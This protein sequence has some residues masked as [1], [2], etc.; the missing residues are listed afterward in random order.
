MTDENTNEKRPPGRFKKT[1]FAITGINDLLFIVKSFKQSGNLLSERV[2]FIR[3]QVKTLRQENENQTENEESYSDVIAR[4][5]RS[6]D[7]LLR[8]AGRSK[9]YWLICLALT[10]L[11]SLFIIAGALRVM[12]SPDVDASA[13]RLLLTLCLVMA[14]AA[15]SAMKAIEFDFLGWRIRNRCNSETEQGTYHFYVLDGGR[16]HAFRSA[17]AGKVRGIDAND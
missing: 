5:S 13:F 8:S 10:G 15:L 1:V 3:K 2:S 6:E 7:D 9:K 4:T 11:V 12:F 17:Q 14:V 16:S